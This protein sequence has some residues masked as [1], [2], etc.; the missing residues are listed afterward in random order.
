MGKPQSQEEEALNLSS[1]RSSHGYGKTSSSAVEACLHAIKANDVNAYI[2][3]TSEIAR[4]QAELSDLRLRRKSPRPLEGIPVAVKDNF[5][6]QGTLTTAGSKILH[7]FV[8]EY[9]ST[10][11][12]LL[13]RAGAV[14]LGKT[15][16]DEFGM[17]SSTE[18]SHFGPTL[19][20]VAKALG[21]ENF[22]PGGSSGGSAAAVA[23]NQAPIALGTDTGGS[24]RQ[25]ASFCGVFGMKPTYGLCS[26]WGVVAYASSLD[27]A[28]VIGRSAEDLATMFD[29]I[30]QPDEKDSTSTKRSFSSF[31]SHI[32][33]FS[34]DFTIGV[35]KQFFQGDHTTTT[36]K[37]WKK[38][39]EVSSSM[40]VAFK[41]IEMPN[42]KYALQAYYV[43]A[44]SEASSNLARYDGVRFGYRATDTET[45]D[46][47]YERSRSE[48]FGD[49]VKRRIMLGTYCLSAGFYDAYYQRARK[50]RTL[51]AQD[52]EK[53]FSE[54][55][56]LAWPT[57]PTSAF[58]VGSHTTDPTD[59]YLQ[60]I[61]TVP[62][63]LAG[64]PAI[65]I[66]FDNCQ[67][68]LPLGLTIAAPKMHD[69]K[70][71]GMA[72]TIHRAAW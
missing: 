26:R 43:I 33:K 2:T 16:M 68:G 17:G 3:V 55:D 14:C 60:D 31:E 72:E 70:L 46:E 8:P 66:P 39:E 53:A 71:L 48:G 5:C 65:S 37:V 40:G 58:E 12:S 45:I 29:I 1:L 24:I 56:C 64:I 69:D 28:G 20:P 9:E 34:R 6:T 49:E 59:M 38:L 25:P 35:P 19:N 62:V 11:S 61:F 18:K 47:L 23:A 54:V 52:F 32:G 67:T 42:V 50:V 15:N 63:N 44:L 36:D 51:V 27:Q 7:N 30:A 57:T 4:A 41:V 10:V 21:L 13:W 22:V